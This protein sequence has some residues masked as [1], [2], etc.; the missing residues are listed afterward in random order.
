M[1][2]PRPAS[3]TR[4]AVIGGAASLLALPAFALAQPAS[5]PARAITLIVPWPSERLARS[6]RMRIVMSVWPPAGHGTI[7]VMARAG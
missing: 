5:Y 1:P 7:S 3:W 6:A 4:R 2:T